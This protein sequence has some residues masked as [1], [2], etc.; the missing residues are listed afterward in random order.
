MHTMKESENESERYKLKLTLTSLRRWWYCWGLW[1]V[2]CCWYTREKFKTP[3]QIRLSMWGIL[4]IF[5]T[6]SSLPLFIWLH[7]LYS[8]LFT[9]F[10]LFS[11][12]RVFLNVRVLIS[13]RIYRMV[14][15]A[16]TKLL[17]SEKRAKDEDFLF[18]LRNLVQLLE[19]VTPSLLSFFWFFLSFVDWKLI[20]DSPHRL[21]KKGSCIKKE[22][23]TNGRKFISLSLRF[24][25]F[26]II[27]F[28]V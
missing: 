16:H 6:S 14:D 10:T 2:R 25:N 9:L 20:A 15:F 27:S 7:T 24:V 13:L 12:L 8:P 3:I 1:G 4:F 26:A 23:H 17:P 18:G 5:S 11:L 22:S 21:R 19:S 28:G